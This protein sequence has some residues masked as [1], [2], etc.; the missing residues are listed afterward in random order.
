[1]EWINT[2]TAAVDMGPVAA[3]VGAVAAA[4]AVALIAKRGASMLLSSIGR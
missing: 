2:V 4:I 3:G 1:M